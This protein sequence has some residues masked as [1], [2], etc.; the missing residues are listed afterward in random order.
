[1][2]PREQ[3]RLKMEMIQAAA[4][5]ISATVR[6]AREVKVVRL[7][8]GAPTALVKVSHEGGLWYFEVSVKMR[9]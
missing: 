7:D 2:H 4:A 5:A 1:M 8:K 9:Y 6:E 3:K